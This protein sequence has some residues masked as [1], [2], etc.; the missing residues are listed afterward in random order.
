M[1]SVPPYSLLKTSAKFVRILEQVK[2][3]EMQTLSGFHWSALEFSQ[4]FASVFTRLWRHRKHVL[5]LNCNNVFI[6]ELKKNH[7]FFTQLL[8]YFIE[9]KVDF[10]RL[11]YFIIGF[12]LNIIHKIWNRTSFQSFFHIHMNKIMWFHRNCM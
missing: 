1:F 10:I 3:L 4:T 9:W 7:I 5:F 2:T 8:L 11:Q 6:T 12:S